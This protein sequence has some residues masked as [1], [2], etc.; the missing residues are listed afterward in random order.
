M[1]MQC[2][3]TLAQVGLWRNP[4]AIPSAMS[5]ADAE[6]HRVVRWDL[7]PPRWR[8]AVAALL[9]AAA[10]SHQLGGVD[11]FAGKKGFAKSM[12]RHGLA[13]ATFEKM[14]DPV[15]EDILSLR[16]LSRLILLILRVKEHGLVMMGPPCKF[17]IFLTLSH[18]KRAAQNLAG[19]MASWMAKEGNAIADIVAD[20][21]KLCAALSIYTVL[22]QPQGSFMF[23]YQPMADALK[24]VNAVTTTFP[25]AVFKH[26]ATKPTRLWGTTPWLEQFGRFARMLPVGTTEPLADRDINGGVTGKG[27]A[28]TASAA[29]TDEFCDCMLGYHLK[30]FGSALKRKRERD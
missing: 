20:I 14:D 25:M 24:L 23:A 28:L 4:V 18:T 26:P 5:V 17:W 27:S 21:V 2:C 11:V 9:P 12:L 16:G 29:Y 10:A 8:E 7:V 22:E 15:W 3:G 13:G 6:G 1:Q 19:S 30:A